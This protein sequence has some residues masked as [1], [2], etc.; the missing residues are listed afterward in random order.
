MRIKGIL[1]IALL[2]VTMAGCKTNEANYRAAYEQAVAN[3]SN[4][5]DDGI[6]GTIYDQ[7]RRQSTTTT[8]NTESGPL[9]VTR[10]RVKLAEP[11]D[12]AVRP[13]DFYV[14]VGQ[15]KQ[16]FNA[17]SLCQRVKDAG[18]GD[19][20]ILMTAEPL[21]FIGIPAENADKLKALYDV[22]GANPPVALKA[23]Y[24]VAFQPAK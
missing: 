1:A 21:Y 15:F 8:L 24:P 3:R 7:V 14:L 2:A 16:L 5:E 11:A 12:K 6:T 9:Q 4:A 13:A 18:Y 19:A 10:Q 17:R 23:P 20:T 22:I